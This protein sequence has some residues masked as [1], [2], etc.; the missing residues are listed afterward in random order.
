MED[1]GLR[2]TRAL[3]QSTASV[4]EFGGSD[5]LRMVDQMLTNLAEVYKSQLA[6]VSIE[7]L[8]RVQAHLKQTLAIRAVIR[9]EAA[10][11]L[12]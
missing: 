10:L 4:A 12:V 1:E 3:Q 5:P 7:E 2:A 9:G 8:V 11:P 6:D